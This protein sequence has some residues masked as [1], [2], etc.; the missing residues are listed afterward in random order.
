MLALCLVSED[1]ANLFVSR[2]LL[3]LGQAQVTASPV[4]QVVFRRG[5][6]GLLD[7]N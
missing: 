2:N 4:E 6:G 3:A 7:L 1:L 5:E